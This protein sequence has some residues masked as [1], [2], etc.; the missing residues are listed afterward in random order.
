MPVEYIDYPVSVITY[1]Y[2]EMW[3]FARYFYSK[4]IMNY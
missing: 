2:Q 3:L 4:N 1:K